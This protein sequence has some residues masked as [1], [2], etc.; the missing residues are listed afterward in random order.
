MY[1]EGHASIAMEEATFR[2]N[3]LQQDNSFYL[4]NLT[5][6][7]NRYNSIQQDNSFYLSNLTFTIN[8]YNSISRTTA[9]IC[10]I[11]HL[12]S[13]GTG[14]GETAKNNNIMTSVSYL[15]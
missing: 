1:K 6:T 8:R 15:A 4:S 9:S 12:P 7:I 2:H 3:S 5:F 13:T 10:L 11:S 14:T